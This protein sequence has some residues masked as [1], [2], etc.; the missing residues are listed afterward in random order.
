MICRE[1][2]THQYISIPTL[3]IANTKTNVHS[4]CRRRTPATSPSLQRNPPAHIQTHSCDGGEDGAWGDGGGDRGED[5]AWGDDTCVYMLSPDV[6]M[7][8]FDVCVHVS[9]WT[10]MQRGVAPSLALSTSAPA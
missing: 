5:D 10:A 2:T 9:T 8:C 4:F 7:R 3:P 6:Y 1:V